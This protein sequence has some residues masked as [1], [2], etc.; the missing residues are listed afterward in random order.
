MRIGID[1]R[2]IANTGIGRYLRNLLRA[3]AR[4]DQHNEYRVWL[5]AED[6][7]VVAQDNFQIICLSPPIPVYSLSE[8]TRLP[9]EIRTHGVDLMHYP[10]FNLPLY[11]TPPSVVTIHDLIYYLYPE[12]CPSR[13]AHYYARFMLWQAIRQARVLITVSE[14]SK[15]D[16][17]RHFRFAADKIQV[18]FQAADE[19]CGVECSQ[20]DANIEQTY[21][22]TRPYILYVG[23]HHPYKNIKTLL[24]AYNRDAAVYERFQLV[25]AGKREDRRSDLYRLAQTLHADAS[26]VF[27]G[28]VA[29]NEL[30]TLYRRARLFVF[31]SCYE[32]FG[33]PPLE[34]MACGAPVVTSNAASLP[35]VVGEAAI[36]ADPF[37]VPAFADAMRHI[38]LNPDVWQHYRRKGLERA[39]TFSWDTAAK[40]LLTIY[41]Q[42]GQ[43]HKRRSNYK[44]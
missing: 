44:D 36:Q 16:L 10:N 37:D 35:E 43:T 30:F 29:E 24:H 23:K 32:G 42:V 26:V 5:N 22:I 38:L 20:S 7:P 4:V 27:T 28:F 21:G 19:R 14:H 3:L 9:R 39:R 8:H 12:Q 31:P 13:L 2:M 25:I 15:Q 40:H 33:L 11:Q 18:V 17:I 34:A 1:A 41:E 6:A